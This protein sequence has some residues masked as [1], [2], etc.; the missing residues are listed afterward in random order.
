MET[1][2]LVIIVS[3]AVLIS[4]HSRYDCLLLLLLLLL[5]LIIIIIIIIKN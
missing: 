1:K 4:V 3:L 5:L 2:S